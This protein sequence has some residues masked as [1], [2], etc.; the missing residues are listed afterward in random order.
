[1]NVMVETGIHHFLVN[2]SCKQRNRLLE[3]VIYNEVVVRHEPLLDRLT[4]GLKTY[5]T[6]VHFQHC[7]SV[8]LFLE[9]IYS[10]VLSG[11]C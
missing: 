4:E 1:M 11:V 6:S 10:P 7:L 8:Y 3:V 5:L 2:S 9:M